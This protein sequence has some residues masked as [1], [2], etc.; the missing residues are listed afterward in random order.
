MI[1]FV[2]ILSVNTIFEVKENRQALSE[3][4]AWSEPSLPKRK[5]PSERDK[6]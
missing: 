2:L 5:P 4:E 1:E 6:A 3:S